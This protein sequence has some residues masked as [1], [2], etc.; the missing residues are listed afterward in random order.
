MEHS[1][2]NAFYYIHGYKPM[3]F[4]DIDTKNSQKTNLELI[5]QHMCLIDFEEFRKHKTKLESLG[6]SQGYFEGY[7]FMINYHIPLI[8]AYSGY[9]IQKVTSE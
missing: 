9:T 6:Y 4:V 1:R 5:K 8:L 7:D 3:D 2:W